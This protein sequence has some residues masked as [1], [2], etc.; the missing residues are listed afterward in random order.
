MASIQSK[1]I[2]HWHSALSHVSSNG[3]TTPTVNT[4]GKPWGGMYVINILA[5][6]HYIFRY[7]HCLKWFIILLENK[8]TE[9]LSHNIANL[10][11]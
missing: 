11:H 1:R 5:F 4:E 8:S 2:C 6:L 9:L 7:L 10:N 3:C